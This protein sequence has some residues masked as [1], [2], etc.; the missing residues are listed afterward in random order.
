MNFIVVI[1]AAVATLEN[2]NSHPKQTHL[3]Y[4]LLLDIEYRRSLPWCNYSMA[5]QLTC[6]ARQ[7]LKSYHY[8]LM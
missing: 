8:D 1:V 3:Q 2:N 7:C 6:M 4:R 5:V